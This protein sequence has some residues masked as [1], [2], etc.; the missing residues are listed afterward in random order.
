[1]NNWGN[2]DPDSRIGTRNPMTKAG[3]PSVLQTQARVVF[4]LAI[5]SPSFVRK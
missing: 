3:A 5:A 4:G 2:M 1:M